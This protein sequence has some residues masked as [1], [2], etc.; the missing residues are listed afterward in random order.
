ML[1]LLM[2]IL[3]M[4][5]TFASSLSYCFFNTTGLFE[6][7]FDYFIN[8]CIFK[9]RL[10]QLKQRRKNS[11]YK[12]V[13]IPPPK[14]CMYLSKEYHFCGEKNNND[15]Y[16]KKFKKIFLAVSLLITTVYIVKTQH[17]AFLRVVNF[18]N[19]VKKIEYIF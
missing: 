18:Y 5:I 8:K 10:P 14:I 3:I 7:L 6:K 4:M 2:T 19:I 9:R 12:I 11:F 13:K 1:L 15:Q 16:P 17:K